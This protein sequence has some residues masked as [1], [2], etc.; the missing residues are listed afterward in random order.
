MK[1]Q[2]T[3]KWSRIGF[4]TL[5]GYTAL[6]TTLVWTTKWGLITPPSN[7]AAATQSEEKV[8]KEDSTDQS[9]ARAFAARFAREYFLWSEGNEDTRKDRLSTYLHPDI[10]VQGGLNLK[11]AEW[12]S[13]AREVETWKVESGG[14]E[15][16]L[17]ATVYV[18]LTMTKGKE[19]KRVDRWVTIPMLKAG[20]SYVV[21]APPLYIPPPQVNLPEDQED[22]DKEKGDSVS[23]D[24]RDD[25]ETFLDS[26]WD[27]YTTGKPEEIDR[28]LF[29]GVEPTE[30]LVGILHY[31]EMDKLEVRQDG[32]DY[33]A[34]CRVK[35]QDLSSRGEIEYNFT[36]YL[37][38]EGTRWYVSSMHLK[39]A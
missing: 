1:V 39:E 32:D 22:S 5:I 38:R 9:T 15:G 11:N 7:P 20:D 37:T 10:D 30:G 4:Y 12:D 3:Q 24:I 21:T 34:D 27:T 16:Q 23:S 29:E 31:Q 28:Y 33:I 18:Q 14:K 19:Q 8:E 35:F 6:S 36:L 17:E 13:W 2:W 25:V 26:F